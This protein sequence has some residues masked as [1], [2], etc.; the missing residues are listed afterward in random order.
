MKSVEI[1]VLE[2]LRRLAKC[3]LARHDPNPY[4]REPYNFEVIEQKECLAL[5]DEFEASLV[6]KQ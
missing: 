1:R 4:Q 5:A 6:K 3:L 2:K